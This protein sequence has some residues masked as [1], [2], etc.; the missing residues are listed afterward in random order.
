M[1]H[2]GSAVQ[3][4]SEQPAVLEP[5][6]LI[7]NA[8]DWGRDRENTDSIL[9]CV[10]KQAVSSVSAMVFMSDSERAAGIARERGI[11]AGLHLNLTTAFSGPG[12]ST[13]LNECQERIARHLRRHRFAPVIWHPGL[14]GAFRFVVVAQIDEYRRLYG[15]PPERID[16]HHHMHLCSNVLLGGLLPTGIIV[17]RNF[18]FLASEKSLANRFYRAVVDRAVERGRRCADFFFSLPPIEPDGRLE[19][20]LALARRHAVELETHAVNPKE[21]SFLTSGEIFRRAKDIP[22]ARSYALPG[23]RSQP[24]N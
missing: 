18:S 14:I 11:D 10:S 21:Y 13:R 24:L 1:S 19:R 2:T 20:I 16:G 17:R 4:A 15:C 8:D 9:D 12:I 5:G 6:R 7:I 23:W 22:V 3:P